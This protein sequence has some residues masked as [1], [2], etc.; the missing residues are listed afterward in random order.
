MANKSY[1]VMLDLTDK[2]VLVIGAG[3]VAEWKLSKLL[4]TGANLQ[5]ISPEATDRVRDWAKAGLLTWEARVFDPA[6]LTDQAL[7][8]TATNDSTVNEQACAAAR[9]KG[10]WVNN[11]DD[12]GL[13]DVVVP[14]QFTRGKLH[15]AVTT[16]GASPALASGISQALQLQYGPEYEPYT[17]FLYQ[18]RMWLN[19]HLDDLNERRIRL[20][21][22]LYSPLLETIRRGEPYEALQDDLWRRITGG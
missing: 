14:A 6:D 17:E 19:T 20:N 3:P 16:G 11:V 22:V 21:I 18:C 13:G 5:V 12:A 8:F 2:R 4:E 15:L 7:V 1:A 10:I 9:A